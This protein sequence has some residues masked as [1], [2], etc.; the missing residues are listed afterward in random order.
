ME[1]SVRRGFAILRRDIQAEFD[2]VKKAKLKGDISEEEKFK[3]EQLLKDL[4]EVEKYIGKEIWDIE[5]SE[6]MS[7]Q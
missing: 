3:E 6:Y 1:E 5:K 4:Q 7:G 2:L